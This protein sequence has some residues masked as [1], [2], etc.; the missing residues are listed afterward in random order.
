M[1]FGFGF[2]I[3]MVLVMRLRMRNMYMA[4]K[5]RLFQYN[6]IMVLDEEGFR[7]D[8]ENG[9]STRLPWSAVTGV[10][11][12][13]DFLIL[14]SITGFPMPV[15][16]GVLSPDAISLIERVTVKPTPSSPR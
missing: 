5:R 10:K 9:L 8:Y 2:G 7:F 16:I 12:T 4:P 1:L 6:R 13:R 3:L 11:W 15:P 14:D